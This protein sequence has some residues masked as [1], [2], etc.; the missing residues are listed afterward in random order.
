MIQG[1]PVISRAIPRCECRLKLMHPI[2]S[3]DRPS[4]ARVSGLVRPELGDGR[5]N[6]GT[7]EL[8][9]DRAESQDCR[10]MWIEYLN[11][12][13][14]GDC[15]LDSFKHGRIN[16]GSCGF[17][18]YETHIFGGDRVQNRRNGLG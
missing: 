7:L 13:P 5:L 4:L 10:L 18:K 16:R 6:G 8:Q 1:Q 15:K 3:S 17:S 12:T 14:Y 2:Q 9:G 11:R